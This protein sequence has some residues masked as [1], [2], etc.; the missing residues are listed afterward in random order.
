[1]K[2]ALVLY[3]T[4]SRN[5][6]NI[7]DDTG[8]ILEGLNWKVRVSSLHSY[9]QNKDSFDPDLLILGAPVHY[10]EIPDTALGMIRRLPQFK[11][12]SGFVFS[13]FGR[14]V[15]N[16]VPYHLAREL[17]SKGVLILGGAQIVMPHS[18]RMDAN[19]RIGDV[20]DSFGKGEPTEENWGKYK[21]VIQD[22]AKRVE[23]GN[24]NEIN[25]NE[26]KKL[27]TKNA[28]A[29][30]MNVCMT[31]GMR[32]NPLPYVQLDNEKCI[33]CH[34]CVAG[35]DNE[36]IKLS[37]DGEI[38]LDKNLCKKCY[39]CI[40]ECGEGALYTKWDQVVFWVRFVHRFSKNNKTVFV[41]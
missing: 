21:S 22:I 27:H 36:A 37:D 11:N 23:N 19:T 41:V 8:R 18:A 34:Q 17:Q 10:W 13:T 5:T 14:C 2:K 24:V 1:M 4:C 39:K 25:V 6:S 32:R 9:H 20:E 16:S 38:L 28:V 15:C 29:S 30:I 12:T 26:L 35:C 7:A 3:Y 40:E 31:P 33:Q